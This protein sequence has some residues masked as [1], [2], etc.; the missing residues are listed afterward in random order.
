M[1][2]FFLHNRSQDQTY[3]DPDGTNLPDLA[4]A[5]A[6]AVLSAREMMAD[7]LRHGSLTPGRSFDIAGEDGHVLATVAFH[8]CLY[9]A[10]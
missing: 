10:P 4:A 6:E 3:L 1:P 2:R 9:R 7:E 5:L 8:D